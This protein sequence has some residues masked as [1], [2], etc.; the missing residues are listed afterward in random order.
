MLHT[1]ESEILMFYEEE[2]DTAIS[3]GD[4]QGDN[5]HLTDFSTFYKDFISFCFLFLGG[6]VL[7]AAKRNLQ[8]NKELGFLASTY[9]C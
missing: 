3:L 5:H 4:L 8:S 6:L 7:I 1:V 9:N 2:C